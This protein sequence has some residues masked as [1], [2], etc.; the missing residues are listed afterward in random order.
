MLLAA[1]V[2]LLA[3]VRQGVACAANGCNFLG[4]LS[5]GFG[6]GVAALRLKRAE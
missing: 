5:L 6:K 3:V 4:L 2:W 1:A